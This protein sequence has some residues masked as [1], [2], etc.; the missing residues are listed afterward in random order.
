M[1]RFSI[2]KILVFA[3]SVLLATSFTPS[4]ARDI[5]KEQRA[6]SDARERYNA[7]VSDDATLS[8]QVADQEKRVATEQARLQELQEKQAQQKSTVENAK[9]DLDAKVQILESVWE[10]RNKNQ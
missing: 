8:K 4:F 6:A 3:F 2:S 5:S 9:A 10:E 7:A 1:Q